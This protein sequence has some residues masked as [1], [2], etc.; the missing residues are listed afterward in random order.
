MHENDSKF[1]ESSEVIGL[2]VISHT[3]TFRRSF[4]KDNLNSVF[5]YGIIHRETFTNYFGPGLGGVGTVAP[6]LGG[7]NVGGVGGG[8]VDVVVSSS[9]CLGVG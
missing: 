8:T 4:L 5:I 2:G 9:G 3:L 1:L 7:Y 6:V